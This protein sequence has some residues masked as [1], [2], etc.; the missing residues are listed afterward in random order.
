M[1]N[2]YTLF[3]SWLNSLYIEE[4]FIF[5]SIAVVAATLVLCIPLSV[6]V[7]TS[8]KPCRDNKTKQAYITY[9]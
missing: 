4:V 1:N 3:Q 9:L 7:K 5:I 8:T 6:R 2:L